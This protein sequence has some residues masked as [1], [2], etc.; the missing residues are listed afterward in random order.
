M[1]RFYRRT[2]PG[3]KDNLE[4]GILAAGL[5]AGVAAVSFYFVR[6]FRSREPLEPVGSAPPLETPPSPDTAKSLPS[7]D[8]DR[9]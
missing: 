8:E 9:G 3:L 2:K 7:A 1:S 4:A 5:A 6:L